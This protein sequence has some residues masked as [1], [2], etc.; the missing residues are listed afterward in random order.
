MIG[1][2]GTTDLRTKYVPNNYDSAY[3]S[4]TSY[5]TPFT[6]HGG[7]VW[8]SCGGYSV[9]FGLPAYQS[10]FVTGKFRGVPDVAMHMGGPAS[11]MSTDQIIVGGQIEEV[12]GTSAAA[13]EFAGLLALR[14]QLKKKPLGDIHSTLYS[15]AKS[16]G[17]FHR[18]IVGTNGYHTTSTL[19]DPVLGLGTPYGRVIDGDPTAALAGDP[20][21]ASNP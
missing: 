17:A 6:G 1:V 8:G 12:S 2:G 7:S 16:S 9:L 19:W 3:V 15:L 13:P 5:D 11:S 14:V 10:G 4:E 21:S 20:R 18:Y